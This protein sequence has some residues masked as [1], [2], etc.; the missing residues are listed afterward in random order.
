LYPP[1][2]HTIATPFTDHVLREL[3]YS[4]IDYWIMCAIICGQTKTTAKVAMVSNFMIVYEKSEG[5][6]IKHCKFRID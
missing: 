3:N 4:A 5:K 2:S 6:S 1:L